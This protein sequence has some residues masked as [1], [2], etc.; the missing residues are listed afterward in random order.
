MSA[1]AV[2]PYGEWPSPI[3]AESLVSGAV[4]ISEVC[5]DGTDI[6]WAEA[7]P[8]E[9]GRTALMRHRDGVTA[10]ISP[11]DA[12]VRTLVHEYGGG[13]WWVQDGVAYYVDVA[14]QRV[15]RLV[16]GEEPTLL[17]PEPDTPR[18]LRFADVRA[19]PDGAWL[20]AVQEDHGADAE[21][22][23]AIVAIAT[24]GSGVRTLWAGSD[25]VSSPRLDPTGDRLAWIAWQHPNMPWDSTVLL[26]APFENGDLGLIDVELGSFEGNEAWVEPGFGPDGTLYAC[27]DRD[28]WWNLYAIDVGGGELT[29]VVTGPF[30]VPTP[31]WVFGMQRWAV[32]DD[33]TVAVA[34]LATGD[35]FILDGRTVSMPD[36]TVTSLQP[37]EDGVVY[38]G[39]GYGHESQVVRLRLD[40]QRVT[41]EVVHAGRDLPVDI[42][43]LIEPESITF[44]TT[45]GP[46]GDEAVAHGLYYPP[47]NPEHIGPDT[48]APPLL[49]LAHGG[50]TGQARRQLQLGIL[51][52]TSRGIAVVDV[53]YRGST[54]YGRTYRRALDGQWGIADVDD[55]VAAA[56]YLADRGDVD[57]NRLMIRGGSAGGFTVLSA[58]AH[59]DVFSA[60]ASRYGV[61]DLE[62]LA[63]DT[64]KFESRYLD[65]LIGPWPEAK[66]T[67]DARSPINH[68]DKLSAPM[69]VLQGD[70][71]AIVPP[72]QSEMIV[73]ALERKGVPVS[74]LLFE[75]EQHGF[76]KAENVVTALEAE[77]AFFGEMLGF[78]PADD[79]PLPDIRRP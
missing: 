70:E 32:T 42:G 43:Y 73:D 17:T 26:S 35:E 29:P 18:S 77:L 74:Y 63:T 46:T 65:T 5:V 4:G 54:G 67:Y 36:A 60:G 58:L 9:G 71:D 3:T 37:A 55:C 39:A 76:R 8:D 20:V 49:V 15:R 40:A 33:H 13:S 56:R 41:R 38:A 62:A 50:P 53:D 61:A 72:N 16:P 45:P 59:H 34:G 14:D 19:T 78:A 23:N 1:P 25:F 69:I 10:E 75:G 6:W 44:A 11:P 52:W 22:A 31:S 24:D 28:E 64:H 30:E 68:V 2:T 79:L 47:T 12:Y 7:R 51:Y 27:T 21:P 57:P 66:P 48:A